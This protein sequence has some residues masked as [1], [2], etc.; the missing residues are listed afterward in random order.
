MTIKHLA[1]QE[2][3]VREIGRL[4]GVDES[5]VRHHLKR[6]ATGAVDGRSKQPQLAESWAEAIAH[7]I[8]DED[9]DGP[10]NLAAL[11]DYLICE[12]GTMEE[13][14][15]VIRA[16]VENLAVDGVAGTGELR[17]KRI[18]DA[19]GIQGFSQS[20]SGDPL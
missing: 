2:M 8:G 6:Q 7:Y 3:P 18:P 16:F 4:L 19:L 11:H 14:K 20:G 17:T 12:H 10:I 5:T 13:R 9:E 1:G 15:R